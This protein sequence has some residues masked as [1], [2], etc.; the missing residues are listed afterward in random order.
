MFIDGHAVRNRLTSGA[1]L[2]QNQ[3]MA[4]ILATAP[5]SAEQAGQPLA[6]PLDE[7]RVYLSGSI[8]KGSGD[9]RDPH[10]FWSPQDEGDLLRN[11]RSARVVALNPARTQLR[12]QD[13]RANYG[14]D[15]HLV[16]TSHVVVVDARTEKGI[17]VGAEMMFAHQRGIPVVSVCPPN[18]NYRRD[19]VPDVFGEDLTDWVHPF[20]AGLSDYLVASFEEAG[21]LLERAATESLPCRAEDVDAA[22]EYYHSAR[23]GW[24]S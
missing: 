22:I 16:A 24:R 3:L 17:G 20:V 10:T 7:L 11:V 8:R 4:D 5:R 6:R 19:Y 12:R 1:V 21:D 14:A 2:C 23:Q 13:Y 15:L 18:T 9:R